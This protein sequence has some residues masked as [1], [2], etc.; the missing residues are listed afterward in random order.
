MEKT[1]VFRLEHFIDLSKKGQHIEASIDLKKQTVIKK[2]QEENPDGIRSETE[3]YLLL[4]EYNFAVAGESKK[5]F[6]IYMF[7]TS[8]ESITTTHQNVLFANERLKID[9]ERLRNARITFKEKYFG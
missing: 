9:Y 1:E 3:M 4:A 6:K 5:V 2:L 8:E 7:G